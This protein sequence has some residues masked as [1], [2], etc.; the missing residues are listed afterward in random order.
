MPELS[1][2]FGSL[3]TESSLGRVW[4]LCLCLA[5]C[6]EDSDMSL[7]SGLCLGSLSV[8][9]FAELLS[10]CCGQEEVSQEGIVVR[11]C[12][13]WWALGGNLLWS[14]DG[15]PSGSPLLSLW[16]ADL[17]WVRGLPVGG[18]DGAGWE[19]CLFILLLV[20]CLYPS[21]TLLAEGVLNLISLLT[22]P[23]PPITVL[24]MWTV[25]PSPVRNVVEELLAPAGRSSKI[26]TWTPEPGKCWCAW[27]IPPCPWWWW[28][29]CG[30]WFENKSAKGSPNGSWFP[31]NVLKRSNGSE[32][33]NWPF[34]EKLSSECLLF[35]LLLPLWSESSPYL[36]K[37]AFLLPFLHFELSFF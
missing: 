17:L 1:L 8:L 19:G 12:W 33:W 3:L 5:L 27:K 32:G 23:S 37:A 36:S 24:V 31:K 22:L 2:L 26:L 21:S 15:A 4:L 14:W 16:G 20:S 30:E 9:K 28:C 35:L 7:G 34:L 18:W 6:G 29:E 11:L 25:P 13:L 10:D